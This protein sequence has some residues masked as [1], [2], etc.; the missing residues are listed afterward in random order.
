MSKETNKR[1]DGF[2]QKTFFF[3]EIIEKE[4]QDNLAK[5]KFRQ[6][7]DG[8]KEL[9]KLDKEKY[10][11]ELLKCYYGIAHQMIR[12][13]QL[14]DAVQIVDNIKALT[15][16]KN[17]GSLDL[18]IAVKKKDYD[19]V[20]RIYATILS[21]GN[22]ISNIP[23][24]SRVADAL[25]VAFREFPQLKSICPNIYEELCAVRQAL[26]DVS[27]E[28]YEEAWLKAKRIAVH[29][30][31]SHWKLFIKGL[32][33]FYKKEDQK[34][35]EALVRLPSDTILQDIARPYMA[36]LGSNTIAQN[37]INE[38]FLQTMCMI[39][40][41]PDLVS[42]LPKADYLWKARRYY[43][44]YCHVRKNMKSFPGEG[45]D[46]AGIL[47]RFYFNSIYHLPDEAAMSYLEDLRMNKM[48]VSHEYDLEE[49]FI[50]K[51]GCLFLENILGGDEEDDN[52][53]AQLWE[54]FLKAYAKVF[55]NNTSLES[56]VY[57]HLGSMFATEKLQ[58][59]PLFPWLPV[60]KNRNSLRNAHLAEHY[61]NKSLSMDK[62][63]KDAYLALLKVYE[64]TQNQSKGNKLL[65]RLIPLFP[66]DAAILTRA[67]ISCVERKSYIKGIKYLEQAARLD[68]LDSTKKDHLAFSYIKAARVYF[69]KGQVDQGRDIF[70]KAIKNGVSNAHDFN[71]GYA[72]IYARWAALELKNKNENAA[73]EKLRL[74]REKAAKLLPLLYFTQLIFRC[75]GLPDVS[76]QKL[77][78]EVNQEW[79]QPPTPENAIAL[80]MIYNYM[81]IFGFAWLKSEMKRVVQ[82]VFDAS[83]KPCSR[84]DALGIISLALSDKQMQKIGGIYIKKMLQKD[85][86]DPHFH[87]LKY[88][89][90]LIHSSRLPGRGDLDELNRILHL[91]E[92]RNSMEL[93]REL[94]K[95]IKAVEELLETREILNYG[96]AF[97]K[98]GM[99]PNMDME[100]L[101]K[102]FEE[103]HRTMGGH[104]RRKR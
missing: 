83:D 78:A 104:G 85:R 16:E 36:L 88:Q 75:Y 55:G 86:D 43:D 18:L 46:I 20:A 37:T 56:L 25:V 53:C 45:S 90:Q 68:P 6:A 87:Y 28:R 61:F 92:K 19:A 34:A 63:N 77:S 101:E 44:S 99:D 39:A 89:S 30:L 23:E 47:T 26:E 35:L 96:G 27:A 62:N 14:S 24:S 72:Y 1:K 82:Y 11:P 3:P 64:K 98:S 51:A 8:F 4:A 67:G 73:A 17:E 103:M 58:E 91:A 100:V 84:E 66:D 48:T 60:D 29:S 70:E 40:G 33:A 15:G 2:V 54:N 74:A 69:D 79:R 57:F 42:V 76:I 94:R 13:G 41:Y 59:P 22:D 102:L 80:L 52:E 81:N 95:K 21:Q 97:D 7:K 10:L 38:P 71:R 12:N 65:D 5:G 93:A 9:C 31:F 49:V 50:C 32:I